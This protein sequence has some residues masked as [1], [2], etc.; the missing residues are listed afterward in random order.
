MGH[1]RVCAPTEHM[2]S[3]ICEISPKHLHLKGNRATA[4]M[5][6]KDYSG[7][8]GELFN[9]QF[10]VHLHRFPVFHSCMI[11]PLPACT[12]VCRISEDC[13]QALRLEPGQFAIA[14]ILATMAPAPGSFHRTTCSGQLVLAL[15]SDCVKCTA[16]VQGLPKITPGW[17]RLV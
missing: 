12:H 3:D 7:A 14:P 8:A 13:R 16:C 15:L 9:P 5:F 10:R 1:T 11:I 4:R 17:V 2:H 6:L